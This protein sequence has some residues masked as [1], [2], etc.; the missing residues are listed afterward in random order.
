MA[1]L[2]SRAQESHQLEGV[3]QEAVLQL[4]R[5]VT[6]ASLAATVQLVSAAACSVCHWIGWSRA[7]L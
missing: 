2:S 5:K 6:A 3:L 7:P 4:E 1:D